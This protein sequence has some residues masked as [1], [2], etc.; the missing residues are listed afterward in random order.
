MKKSG[1]LCLIREHLELGFLQSGSHFG[2]NGNKSIGLGILGIFEGGD[3]LIMRWHV[4]LIE[5]GVLG[6]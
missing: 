4:L 3:S 2:G 1:G 5:V 6:Y